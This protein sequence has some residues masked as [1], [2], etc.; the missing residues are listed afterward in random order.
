M[1]KSKDSVDAG[2]KVKVHQRIGGALCLLLSLAAFIVLFMDYSK[3][4][5]IHVGV[6][7]AV[8]LLAV[9]I[10]ATAVGLALLFVSVTPETTTELRDDSLDY[11]L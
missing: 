3:T 10:A 1:S 11:P 7:G 8:I 4:G 6:W 2:A 5:D 9:I